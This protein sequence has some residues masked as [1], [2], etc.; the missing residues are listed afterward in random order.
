MKKGKGLKI[1]V[2]GAGTMGK[3][4]ARICSSSLPGAKLAAVIDVEE[5]A[6]QSVATLYRVPFYKSYA[7]AAPSLDALIVAAPT[8]LHFEIARDGLT[9]GKHLL[10]EKPLAD[11][12]DKA[13][14]LC[15]LSRKNHLILAVGLIER[16]NPAFKNLGNY[17]KNEKVVGIEF[18]RFSPYPARISDTNV[19]QD[20]MIHDLDLLLALFPNDEIESVRAK[21]KKVNGPRL[22]E[23]SASICFRSGL[24]AKV[25]ASRVFG[26]ITRN[27]AVSTDK[28]L[29]EVDLLNKTFL[30]RDFSS[31]IPS[32]RFVETYD[33]LTAELKNFVASIKNSSVPLTDGL[34]GFRALQLAERVEK[35]CS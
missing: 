28:G 25:S 34:S 35:A 1:G 32:N 26:S 13:K 17:L 15:D 8:S 5:Q 22:D 31:H 16:Y 2:I 29:Y 30:F 19:I 10:V 3:H 9:A 14:I 24:I 12:S 7:E 33:P 4:H 20:M 18:K 6:A 21:G 27:I 23:A 11:N